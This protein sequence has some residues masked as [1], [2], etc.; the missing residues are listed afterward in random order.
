MTQTINARIAWA[1]LLKE[2]LQ[3]GVPEY[4]YYH[5]QM[6]IHL[7]LHLIH[8]NLLFSMPWKYR[9]DQS[10]SFSTGKSLHLP[11]SGCR[12]NSALH[13]QHLESR[14]CLLVP[15]KRH[16][17]HSFSQHR[18]SSQCSPRFRVSDSEMPSLLENH[19]YLPSGIIES[20]SHFART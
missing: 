8:L 6:L 5:S 19:F 18:Y 15:R 2:T 12:K 1:M 3:T 17:V 9:T 4:A 10:N 13:V 14:F 20:C 11:L 16:F 7:Q